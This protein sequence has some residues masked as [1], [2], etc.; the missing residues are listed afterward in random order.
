MNTEKAANYAAA[1]PK[2][3]V[4]YAAQAPKM[5]GRAP[6]LANKRMQSFARA[7][8]RPSYR[9]PDPEDYE[10]GII[11]GGKGWRVRSDKMGRHSDEEATVIGSETGTD[12]ETSQN[13]EFDFPATY[14]RKKTDDEGK[15]WIL[16][17]FV[18]GDKEDP[19]NWSRAYKW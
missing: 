8:H 18:E 5:A 15:E 14:T 2:N 19:K 17:R 9:K 1:G 12:K 4:H 3:A 6:T 10:K 11:G 13:D 16:L 7:M